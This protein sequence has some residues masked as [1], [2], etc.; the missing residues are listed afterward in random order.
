MTVAG[1]AED[2]GTQDYPFS[3]PFNLSIP[4]IHIQ[5]EKLVRKIL[6]KDKIIFLLM[7]ISSILI[8]FLLDYVLI[9]LGEINV[10]H[11]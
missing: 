10:A 11:S 3:C 5:I 4:S 6:L 8:T 7:I 9:L 1:L 2:R